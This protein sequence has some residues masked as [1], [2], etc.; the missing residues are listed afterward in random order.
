MQAVLK[1]AVKPQGI[2]TRGVGK[3]P[4]PC[5][6]AKSHKGHH[7]SHTSL[8]G[9]LAVLMLHDQAGCQ[10]KKKKLWRELEEHLWE[11]K[12]EKWESVRVKKY[13]MEEGW[14]RQGEDRRGRGL[15]EKPIKKVLSVQLMS[16]EIQRFGNTEVILR[17][18][19]CVLRQTLEVTLHTWLRV[20]ILNLLYRCWQAAPLS[21]YIR[22]HV[23]QS[24]N[25]G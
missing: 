9:L 25:L 2:E 6:I 22:V 12:G 16:C 4:A 7:T 18:S 15:W 21:S 1:R 24:R 20:C 13:Q 3:K 14:R 8:A 10:K 11:E 23:G 19:P 5:L 17:F